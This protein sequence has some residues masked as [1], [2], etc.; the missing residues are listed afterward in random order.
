MVKQ[1]RHRPVLLLRWVESLDVGQ[2]LTPK[3]IAECFKDGLYLIEILRRLAPDTKFLGVQRRPKSAATCI[4]NL[5]LSL[6]VIWQQSVRASNM[7][8]AQELY[9]STG[10]E[11]HFLLL[12]EIFDAFVLRTCWTR[13]SDALVW[14]AS[15]LEPY[16]RVLSVDMG[17]DEALGSSRS[18]PSSAVPARAL[19]QYVKEGLWSDF[20]SGVH[21]FCTLHAH[22]RVLYRDRYALPHADPSRL[23]FAPESQD[24]TRTNVEYVFQLMVDA[25]VPLFWRPKE[26]MGTPDP[27]F[28]VF[29]LSLMHSELETKDTSFPECFPAPVGTA[30][31]DVLP[32]CVPVVWRDQERLAQ[33]EAQLQRDMQT[34]DAAAPTPEP[35]PIDMERERERELSED[36]T[37]EEAPAH[38][39]EREREREHEEETETVPE[40]SAPAA[41]AKPAPKAK[42]PVSDERRAIAL[43]TQPEG[44][45]FVIRGV[46]RDGPISLRLGGLDVSNAGPEM[47]PTAQLLWHALS[48]D[49]SSPSVSGSIDL[50]EIKNVTVSREVIVLTPRD[51]TFRTVPSTRIELIDQSPQHARQFAVT[52]SIVLQAAY[53]TL[54]G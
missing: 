31:R 18:G 30:P 54:L 21:L 22:H 45:L 34:P 49:E 42:D 29:Q 40:A 32:P 43:L 15:I 23:Y 16:G 41:K 39:E 53:R 1:P 10:P 6:R 9:H 33:Y 13:F 37:E 47:L 28:L 4:R 51:K 2:S 50:L 5:E 19:S 11:K 8:T 52:L 25:G 14:F 38:L 20:Q 36:S 46:A 24:E 3:N 17:G 7:P 27:E 26:W 48:G 35:R 12:S 44:I